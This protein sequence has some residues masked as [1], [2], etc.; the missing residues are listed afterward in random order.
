MKHSSIFADGRTG[1]CNA[2]GAAAVKRVSGGVQGLADVG[3]PG[4]STE[5]SPQLSLQRSSLGPQCRC[6]SADDVAR[7]TQFTAAVMFA[8]VHARA[9][10][11]RAP[12]G[13]VRPVC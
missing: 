8:S 6:S 4:P 3:G 7:A 2:T 10:I 13:H 12:L 11:R 9:A 1:G 5:K